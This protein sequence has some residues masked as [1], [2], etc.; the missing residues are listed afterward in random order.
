VLFEMLESGIEG[1]ACR[2]WWWSVVAPTTGHTCEVSMWSCACLVW[3]YLAIFLQVDRGV[4][5]G[6]C[7]VGRTDHWACS[8]HCEVV[9]VVGK[10]G[11]GCS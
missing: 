5:W 2:L 11:F 1:W 6:E 7:C 3:A 4:I 9:A 10:N 8:R